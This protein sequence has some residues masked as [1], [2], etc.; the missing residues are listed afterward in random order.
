MQDP[1]LQPQLQRAPHGLLVVEVKG[2]FARDCLH[3]SL[4]GVLGKGTLVHRHCHMEMCRVDY[5]SEHASEVLAKC[6]LQARERL[7]DQGVEPAT[8]DVWPNWTRLY[9]KKRQRRTAQRMQ[10]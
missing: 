7:T 8:D 10:R 6:D 2:N 9:P 4:G 3:T 1:Q 5:V